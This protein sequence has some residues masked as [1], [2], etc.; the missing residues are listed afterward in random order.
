MKQLFLPVVSLVLVVS[1]YQGRSQVEYVDPAIGGVS[2]FLVPTRPTVHLPNSMVRVYPMRQD[3]LD[4]LM[5][6]FPL[7]IIS[8][9]VTPGMI[10]GL[11]LPVELPSASTSIILQ[12]VISQFSF[13]IIFSDSSNIVGNHMSSESSKAT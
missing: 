13:S 2:M 3:Q 10:F 11:V 4:E 12:K 8:L 9:K 7:T 5:K 1:A 6:P